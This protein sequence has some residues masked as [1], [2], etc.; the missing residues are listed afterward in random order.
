MIPP[1]CL[2]RE[3]DRKETGRLA[4][5]TD[6]GAM[7]SSMKGASNEAAQPWRRAFACRAQNGRW[8]EESSRWESRDGRSYFQAI[9]DFVEWVQPECQR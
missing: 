8:D 3:P 4:L 5:C 2:H 9:R 7:E 1:E 6:H